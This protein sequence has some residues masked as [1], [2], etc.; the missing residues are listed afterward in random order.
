MSF[1][2]NKNMIQL[3]RLQLIYTFLKR[4]KV[5]YDDI[6]EFLSKYN[7]TIGIRQIQRDIKELPLLLKGNEHLLK[8]RNSQKIIYFTIISTS[9]TSKKQEIE[10]KTADNSNF[11]ELIDKSKI[12][13][14]FSIIDNAI[15]NNLILKIKK[16]KNDITGDNNSFDK[17]NIYFIPLKRIKHRGSYYLGGF[18]VKEKRYQIFDVVQLKDIIIT[19]TSFLIEKQNH[20]KNFEEEYKNRFGVTKNIDDTIYTIRINFTSITGNFIKEHNWHPTQ[21][22]KKNGNII[23]MELTCGI[24]RELIGWLFYWMYNCTVVEPQILK[25]LYIKTTDEIVKINQ[26]NIPLLYKN[27]FAP[28]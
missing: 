4:K 15:T 19:E 11:F 1:L 10:F 25:D 3:K 8:E 2:F 9:K 26:K 5:N 14:N 16:L 28:N 23:Q 12:S 7:V 24:N 13:S 17:S 22:F 18:N 27:I 21:K 6:I 20:Y